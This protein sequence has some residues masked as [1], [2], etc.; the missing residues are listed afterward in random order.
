MIIYLKDC[1]YDLSGIYK[2]NFPN[3]KSY[4][5]MSNSIKRRIHE[6]NCSK[7]RNILYS[8]IK[9]YG[10]ISKFELLEKISPN[11]REYM[12]EREKYYISLYKTLITENGY[13]ILKGGDSSNQ[14][15]V[16]S[17]N[18]KFS[19]KELEEIWEM[20]EDNRLTIK[21]ISEK[22]K[23]GMDIIENINLGITYNNTERVYPIRK[24]R[25]VKP[26]ISN[27]IIIEIA[28]LLKET[29]IYQKDI[30]KT[31]GVSE[32]VVKKIN[33]GEGPYYIEG[34]IYPIRY[35]NSSC[36]KFSN[37]QVNLIISDL[38]N[39]HKTQEEIAIKFGCGR[40]LISQ[41]NTGKKYYIEGYTYPI[42]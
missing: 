41:I 15:G 28:N 26:K 30:A 13:N 8:V 5:G 27:E 16:N 20:L 22:M 4:I 29:N 32:K 25:V 12:E 14:V 17:V 1:P 42:R 11:E 31:Y 3:G 35:K 19:E 10:K 7:P 39:T 40:K 6:H 18:A 34:Y 36:K 38:L 21:Q 37:E 23:V 24:K 33:L 9:K 2:L